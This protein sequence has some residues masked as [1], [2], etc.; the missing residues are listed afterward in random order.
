MEYIDIIHRKIISKAVKNDLTGCLEC[1][2]GLD[3]WGYSRVQCK[4]KSLFAHRAVYMYHNGNIDKSVFV[5]HKCDN[6]KCVNIEHLFAGTPYENVKDA[7]QK[8]R[9]SSVQK[10]LSNK[11]KCQKGHDLST[12][13]KTQGV[14]R[15]RNVC[16]M[17]EREKQKSNYNNKKNGQAN[18]TRN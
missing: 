5:C 6:P 12:Y 13:L 3:R 17:C 9:H 10:S 8:R 14:K 11:D 2:I 18:I 15:K 16:L 4:G 1:S 7:I